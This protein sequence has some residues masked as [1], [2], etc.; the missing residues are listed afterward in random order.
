MKKKPCLFLIFLS[1]FIFKVG[2]S[3]ERIPSTIGSVEELAAGL[4][5]DNSNLYRELIA[6]EEENL[7]LKDQINK[8]QVQL[9]SLQ[10]YSGTMQQPEIQKCV[11]EDKSIG[12]QNLYKENQELKNSIDQLK[13]ENFKLEYKIKDISAQ[14]R[15]CVEDCL[16]RPKIAPKLLSKKAASEK[17]YATV[18]EKLISAEKDTHLNLGVNFA[19]KEELDKA[20]AEFRK[21]LD[22]DPFDKDAHF[23]LAVIYSK[24][25]D[26]KMAIREYEDVLRLDPHDKEAYYNLALIYYNNLRN[27]DKAMEYYDK[28]SL[29]LE[30]KY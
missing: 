16:T 11:S 27:E 12:Y 1:I 17:S 9:Q 29:E 3:Q 5:E 4:S 14:L 24:Q 20:I 7:V 6:K 30:R 22:I 8:L 26:Y 2:L 25:Q 19:E 18:E 15:T 28:F 23:N 21:I 13:Q 10:A